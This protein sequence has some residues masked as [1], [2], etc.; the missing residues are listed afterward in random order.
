[1]STRCLSL[2]ALFVVA[3]CGGVTEVVVQVDS[4]GLAIP[5]QIDRVRIV[6]SNPSGADLSSGNTSYESP[7]ITLCGSAPQAGCQS[8]PISLTLVPGPSDGSALVRV[9]V[10]GFAPGQQAPTITD[11]SVFSFVSGTRQQLS[12]VLRGGNCLGMDCAAQNAVCG[13]GGVCT[14]LTPTDPKAPDMA[15]SASIERILFASGTF[16]TQDLGQT[17][18]ATVPAA[19]PGDLMLIALN[20]A[21]VDFAAALPSNWNVLNTNAGG[22]DVFAIAYAFAKGTPDETSILLGN[23][24]P[25][26]VFGSLDWMFITYRGVAGV[27]MPYISQTG[28][29][30][31]NT[32][33]GQPISAGEAYLGLI[34]NPG[35]ECH[36]TT[37]DAMVQVAQIWTLFEALAPAPE[38]PSNAITCNGP[39]SVGIETGLELVL[40]PVD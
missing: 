21:S 36:E 4:D 13:V 28:L 3:G 14:V 32:L 18:S 26:T 38:E 25:Q 31:S 17:F 8:L 20:A 6:V 1:M 5:A 35:Y 24:P 19:Q 2:L 33:P 16:Q 7:L 10:Q 29:A 22:S 12:F 23:S 15:A 39:A 34:A 37:T 40:S 11:A 27:A 30:S 9:E